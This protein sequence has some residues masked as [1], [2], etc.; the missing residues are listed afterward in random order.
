MARHE[1]PAGGRGLFLIMALVAGMAAVNAARAGGAHSGGHGDGGHAEAEGG[2]GG[3]SAGAHRHESWPAPPAAYADRRSDRWADLGAI[4][5]GR[6]LYR[7][8]CM[9]CHGPGGRGDGPLAASLPHPPADLTRHFHTDRSGDAYLFWR[10]SAGGTAEPFRSM[11]STMPAFKE[12][13]TEDQRWD[14]L[15]YVHTFFHLGLIDWAGNDNGTGARKPVQ[16]GVR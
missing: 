14:V 13:L 4:Q 10:V 1:R 5:R 2:H 3:A 8:H 9:Q 7:R 12:R 16:G 15:A 6:E 11:K